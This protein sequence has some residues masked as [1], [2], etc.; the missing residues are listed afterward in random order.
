MRGLLNLFAAAGAVL[1]GLTGAA[2]AHPHIFIDAKATLVFND[3][4]E[5]AKIHNSWTFDEAFSVWQIQGLDTNNDGITSSDEMQSLADENLKGLAE[6]GFYV[7]AGE[8]QESL[9]FTAVGG[10]TFAF[11]DNRSTLSFDIAPETAYRIKGKL[12]VAIADPEYYIA[13]TLARPADVTLEGAPAQC[14][15]SLQPGHDMSENLAAQLFAIPP[16]VTK[17][18]PDLEAKLRGVQGSIV[19]DCSAAKAGEV[20]APATA[21]EAVNDVAEAKVTLPFGGPPAEPGFIL[22]R[23]GLLGWVAKMQSDFYQAM[24]A[25]L[26]ELKSD[27]NA[28]WLLGGLSFLYGI[29]HAAGPGHGKVVIGSYM[30]ANERQVRRG[31]V[32][33]FA[34]ALMQSLVAVVFIGV[35]AAILGLSSIAMGTAVGWMETASYGFVAL[36][37][38]WLIGRKVFGWG[39]G[40]SHEAQKNMQAVARAHLGSDRHALRAAPGPSFQFQSA[41]QPA[42]G[43]RLDAYGRVPGDAHYGHDHGEAE[44]EHGHDHKHVVTAEETLG[45]WREQ[46][47]VVIGVGLRPCTGALVVLVF[48]LSQGIL[49]AGIASV[50]LM[51]LGTAITVATLATLAVSAKGLARRLLGRD[52]R[53]GGALIWWAE[54]AG[55][56]VVFGFGVVLFLATWPL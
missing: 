25:S 30:L 20:A 49:L 18:P 46:L 40:H 38:L 24:T 53:L 44:H 10:A 23:T 45:D 28:F 12:D 31:I 21:L 51:G 33:S 32:L 56:V 1:L 19:V 50:F 15:A 39:H 47:G 37:G 3:R 5:L 55:A 17:L 2:M 26:G 13:I 52:S 22:P 9:G 34:A 7:S 35:A 16:D 41:V 36:L 27:H 42:G 29:F 6:Y 14:V 54:L 8:G 43:A 4:G 11:K 48:A